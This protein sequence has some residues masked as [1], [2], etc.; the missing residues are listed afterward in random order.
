MFLVNKR[1]RPWSGLAW[2]FKFRS[3]MMLEWCVVVWS[4]VAAA[5]GGGGGGK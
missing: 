1:A 5:R 3:G 2:P 4:E